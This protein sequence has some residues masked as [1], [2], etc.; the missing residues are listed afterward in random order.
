[1]HLPHSHKPHSQNMQPKHRLPHACTSCPAA[2]T[3]WVYPLPS[4]TPGAG[5]EILLVAPT[6]TTQ[7]S[8]ATKAKADEFC[9]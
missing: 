5:K 9:K 8:D 1:M 2:A 4:I 6:W 3:C 7:K